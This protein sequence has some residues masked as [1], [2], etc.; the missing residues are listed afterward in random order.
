MFDMAYDSHL[1][2]RSPDAD[3]IT[4][5][6]YEAKMIHQFDHRFASFAP[7]G[8]DDCNEIDGAQKA[9]PDVSSLPRY[10][11]NEVDYLHKMERTD[12][13]ALIGCGRSLRGLRIPRM[14]ER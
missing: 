4:L 13:T 7:N 2:V 3:N 8:S 5:P 1:F 9:N 10:W 14:N 11:V 6:L 12:W